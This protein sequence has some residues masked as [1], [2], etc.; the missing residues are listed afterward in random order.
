[1]TL[2]RLLGGVALALAALAACSYPIR[3]DVTP[4][5][6]HPA[7][8]WTSLQGAGDDTLIV[9]TASG[10]GTRAAA[11]AMSV[12]QAMD[13]VKLGSGR[14]MA[15]HVDIL[16]SVSGG[17]VTAGWFA[18]KGPAGFPALENDFLRRDGMAPL[19]AGVLNPFSAAVTATPGKERIDLLI[20]YLDRQL[21][22]DV[23]FAQLSQQKRRPYLILNAAD[24]VEGT[25]FPFTQYNLD[26]L[27]SDLT[28]MKLSTAVAASAA[29]PVALAPVTLKN[30]CTKDKPS[31]VK[32][33]EDAVDTDWYLNPSRV[34]WGRTAMAYA[35]GSKQYIHLLDGGIADNLG[36][37]EP[38]R[39]LTAGDGVPLVVNDIAQ[40]RIRK[41][42]FV[43]INARSFKPSALDRSQATPGLVDM[44]LA[45]I[46]SSIDR[47]TFNTAERLR[48]LL[49]GQYRLFAAQAQ[50][51]AIK[52][53]FT[54]AADN[55]RLITIDFDA[56][57]DE[58]CRRNFHS[59]A[60]SWALSPKEIDALKAVGG[61]LLQQDPSF[62]AA[63]SMIGGHVSGPIP[64]VTDA[65]KLVPAF[66]E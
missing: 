16:S 31:R 42:V 18:L 61:G 36:V 54:A 28:P 23:T 62:A 39:L 20:D 55:M 47:A 1:M 2:F 21:F 57:G 59:I 46:N 66:K 6:P 38:Y 3:N 24:M 8:A 19:F 64:T 29:F 14:S 32:W 41:I 17:S 4:P 45:S 60:T 9:V 12:L 63:V 48:T 53:N 34:A 7:Y 37:A 43:M 65:C 33:P 30:Y 52:A 35:N 44:L 49:Q 27:C 51:P 11:L 25:P 56:I 58:S 26:L 10:G 15:E 13:Q 40:G 22:S 5:G 50:N